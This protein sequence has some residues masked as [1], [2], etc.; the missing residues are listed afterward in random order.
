M[1]SN[2]HST[3]SSGQQPSAHPTGRPEER[4]SQAGLGGLVAAVGELAAQDLDRLADP[5]LAE[6][7]VEL[8][9]LV[10]RLEGQWL[11]RLAAVDARGAAGA[12]QGQPAP[13]TAGWLR[14][15]LR[16][17]AAVAHGHLRAARA[18]F[19]GPCPLTETAQALVA[20]QIS[21]AHA[22]V[23]AD[24]THQLPEH[25]KLDADPVLAELAGRVD[26]PRLRQA[27]EHLGQVVDPDGADRKAE[28]RHG[29]RG[30]WL[31]ATWQGMVAVGGL[32]EPE[33]GSTVL[34]ALE[35][36]ARP[37]DA[38]DRRSGGQRRADALAELAR[39]S[40]EGGWLPKAGG[41]R[42]QLLVTVDLDSLLGR[43]GGLGGEV[44]GAGPLS[45][46]ACRRLACD[47]TVTRVLVSRQPTPHPDARQPQDTRVDPGTDAPP[48][49]WDPNERVG[50]H[51]RLRAA[52]TRLPPTLGGAPRQP[53]EVG[54][55]TRVVQPAQ[56]AALAVRDGGCVFPAGDRPL[57][58]C[59][60]HHLHH[61]VEGGPTDLGNLALLCRAHHRTVHEGGWRLIRGPDGRFTATP[62]QRRPRAA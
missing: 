12:D 28:R 56:R 51:Q 42:P 23:V 58:W 24:G 33:A 26:P 46:Q 14:R 6:E 60:A 3:P 36:L 44:G 49:A 41:V 61:W 45:A 53:L 22:K 62:P 19:R 1:D 39:R 21:P 4:D 11:R 17:S 20:G 50:L 15:R 35:P 37:T 18:L 31:S 48:A 47:G 30:L 34:A 25:L 57:G 8:R 38:Q 10:D 2:T 13:S 40:V 52:V 27:V 55:A 54:R 16:L 7:L 32:L 29:R 43:P 59:E 9:R 5:A